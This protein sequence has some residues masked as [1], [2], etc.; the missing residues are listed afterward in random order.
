MS[1]H[2]SRRFTR[3]FINMPFLDNHNSHMPNS[4]SD[5]SSNLKR[6]IMQN[7]ALEAKVFGAMVVVFR[8][9]EQHLPVFRYNVYLAN[10]QINHS[11]IERVLRSHFDGRHK[12][13]VGACKSA[14]RKKQ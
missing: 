10:L 9:R 13:F 8:I 2:L 12:M 1:S 4:Y 5:M 11:E 6:E 3:V 7:H 14:Q